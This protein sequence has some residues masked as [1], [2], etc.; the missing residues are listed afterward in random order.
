MWLEEVRE[1]GVVGDDI[2]EMGRGW[3]VNDRDEAFF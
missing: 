3:R 1:E 2:W